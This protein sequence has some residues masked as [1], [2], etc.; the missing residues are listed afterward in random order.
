M[1]LKSLPVF[2]L[3]PTTTNDISMDNMMGEKSGGSDMQHAMY[4]SERY[5]KHMQQILPWMENRGYFQ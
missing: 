1:I 5:A 3:D 4:T 2:L